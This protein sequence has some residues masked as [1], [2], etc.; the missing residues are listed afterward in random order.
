[1]AN[2]VA[3][4]LGNAVHLSSIGFA[5]VTADG[6]VNYANP[7]FCEIFLISSFETHVGCL[8]LE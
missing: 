2:E 3:Q 7:A 6:V 1:M 4:I 8:L 5:V